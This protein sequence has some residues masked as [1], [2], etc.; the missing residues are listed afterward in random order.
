MEQNDFAV[1]FFVPLTPDNEAIFTLFS[2][3]VSYLRGA[4]KIR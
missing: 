3:F 1:L 2:S 4:K